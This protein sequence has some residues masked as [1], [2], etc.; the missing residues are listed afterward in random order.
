LLLLTK[1]LELEVLA[2]SAELVTF[3][4]CFPD[5]VQ[6][7]IGE[8]KKIKLEYVDDYFVLEMD[9]PEWLVLSCAQ[10]P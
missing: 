7:L 8:M 1:K 3:K 10:K 6:Y 9:L 4:S 2:E 5:R